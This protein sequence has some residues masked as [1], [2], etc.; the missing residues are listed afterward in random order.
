[1]GDSADIA[2]LLAS[3]VDAAVIGDVI[4]VLRVSGRLA[5]EPA[6]RVAGE[7]ERCT[8]EPQAGS[9]AVTVVSGK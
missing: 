2:D 9:S 6:P 4:G 3:G 8:N 7:V 5:A 1:M